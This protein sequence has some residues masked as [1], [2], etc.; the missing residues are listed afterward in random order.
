MPAPLWGEYAVAVIGAGPGGLAAARAA[1]ERGTRVVLIDNNPR[2]G[3]QIWRADGGQENGETRALLD[4][5]RPDLLLGHSVIDAYEPGGAWTLDLVGAHGQRVTIAADKVILAT[6]AREIFLPFPGWTLPGVVGVGGLQAMAKNGFDVSGQRVLIAGSGPL[7]LA[8]AA[9]LAERGAELVSICEQALLGKLA[10]FMLQL[11]PFF[12]KAVQG[13]TYHWSVAPTPYRAGTWVTRARGDERVEE[14]EMTDGKRTWREKCDILAIGYGLTPNTELARLMGCE[15][16]GGAVVVSEFMEARTALQARALQEAEGGPGDESCTRVLPVTDASACLTEPG[17][18]IHQPGHSS[19][20]EL[21]ESGHISNIP[22][23][24]RDGRA[25]GGKV[26][27]IGETT[28]IGGVNAALIEG[29]IAGLHAAGAVDEAHDLLPKRRHER[30]FAAL[31]SETFALRPEVLRLAEADT[32]ICRCEDVSM[33]AL[34]GETD[35]RS[36]KLHTRCGMGACQ[37]RICGT[38]L[39]VLKGWEE[40]EVRP[41]LSPVPLRFWDST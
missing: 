5:S 8:V 34:D 30:E 15:T 23:R 38:A 1:S 16:R 40:P 9:S 29:Q 22:Q 12:G 27:A 39:R 11:P 6:G 37:G 35:S 13:L 14:V 19:A 36:A 25:T 24:G 28:G 4:G 31:L 26:Y 3:G 2:P 20:T 10:R 33:G 41:P 17:C 32:T 21:Q 18:T 7:L